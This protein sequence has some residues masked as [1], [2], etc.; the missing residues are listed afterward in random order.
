LWG[1]TVKREIKVLV[2]DLDNTL[3]D[4]F[5]IWYASFSAMLHEIVR[6]SGIPVET[7]EQEIKAVHEKHGTSEYAFLIEELPSLIAKHPD[8]KLTEVYEPAITAYRE[9]RRSQLVLYPSALD[10][11]REI[12]AKRTLVIGYTES[13]EFYTTYRLIKLGLDGLLDFVYFPPDHA[14]P[15]GLTAG[16]I[17]HYTAEA[18]KLHFTQTRHTPKGE[19]KPNPRLL[20]RI[21]EESGASKETAAYI[22]D[23]L[24]KDVRMAQAAGV[25]D[26]Y[27]KYGDTVRDERYELL[28]RVTHWPNAPVEKERH[29]TQENVSP[30]YSLGSSFCQ[31][32]E[33]FDF[34]AFTKLTVEKSV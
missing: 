24:D 33:I 14:L 13:L 17:R 1:R 3:F 18:Y 10:T 27:A 32:L 15:E 25:I 6:I 7:L 23:K 20:S 9:A 19:T 5:G 12:K 8:Q 28:R 26:V 21:L 34:K 4:W 11:L 2:T 16:Q 29:T 31:L 22:G 30:T